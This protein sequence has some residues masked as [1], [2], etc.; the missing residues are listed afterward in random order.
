MLYKS[1]NQSKYRFIL[2]IS[3][4]GR[5]ARSLYQKLCQINGYRLTNAE[6]RQ[7]HAIITWFHGFYLKHDSRN[8]KKN[9]PWI[10]LNKEF[11]RHIQMYSFRTL[12]KKSVSFDRPPLWKSTNLTILF[13]ELL[14][15]NFALLPQSWPFFCF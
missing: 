5:I 9:S 4:H 13:R 11:V 15:V 8:C 12:N 7:V 2:H 10:S 14:V 3:S 6:D 1:W